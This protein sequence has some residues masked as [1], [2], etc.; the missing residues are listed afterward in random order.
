MNKA[1]I[2]GIAGRTQLINFVRNYKKVRTMIEIGSY[3][4]ESTIFFVENLSELDILYTIDPFIEGY[5]DSDYTSNKKLSEIH[6]IFLDNI[7]E[8]KKI[9]HY[10]ETSDFFF[11]KNK[12]MKVDLIYIDGNHRYEQ[13]YKDIKNYIS[14]L[15]EPKI[16]SG[17]DYNPY[18]G[19]FKAVNDIFKRPD[20]LFV[21][22]SWAVKID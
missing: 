1:S 21:D 10:R 17:H 20:A 6:K 3:L 11:E 16:I 13:V 22:T 9:K 7:K 2:V 12:E 4:G 5:D 15:T 18:F 19:V 14:L 8:Y